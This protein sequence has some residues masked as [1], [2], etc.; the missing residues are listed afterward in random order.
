MLD[1]RRRVDVGESSSLWNSAGERKSEI[2]LADPS[3]VLSHMAQAGILVSPTLPC[4]ELSRGWLAGAPITKADL[5]R[6]HLVIGGQV[7]GHQAIDRFKDSRSKVI[8][9][10]DQRQGVDRLEQVLSA[11]GAVLHRRDCGRTTSRDSNGVC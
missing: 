7:R 6:V 1:L 4:V 3:P 9:L 11:E 8:D 5:R 2:V 10:L